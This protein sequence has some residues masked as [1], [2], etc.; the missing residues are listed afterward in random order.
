MDI[1]ETKRHM[2]NPKVYVIVHTTD[3]FLGDIY[4]SEDKVKEVVDILNAQELPPDQNW[5]YLEREVY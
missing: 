3:K 1:Q 4:F 5:D 2:E